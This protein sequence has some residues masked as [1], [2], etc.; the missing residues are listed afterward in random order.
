[1]THLENNKILYDLQHGF[2]SSR[3]C[4]TQLTTFIH[5]LT[6]NNNNNKQTDIIIMDFAKAFDKVPH[7]RLQYKL[8]YYGITGNTHTWITDFLS[9]RTQTVVLEGKQ[10]DK[11]HVTS[12][13]PQGTCLGPILFLIYINDF[14]EYIKHSTLRLFADDSIIYKTIHNKDDTDKLQQD[15][16]AA[17]QWETDWLM[18]FHPDKCNIISITSKRNKIHH[19]YKLHNHTLQQVESSKYLGITLQNNLKWDKHINNITANANRSL[20]FLK[21]NLKLNSPHI[22][23]HAYKALVR[24]KLEYCSSIWDPYNTNQIQQI[25]KPQRRA[26]RYVQNRYHNTSSVTDMLHTL[27]W[28]T[29]QIRRVRTRIILLYKIVHQQVAIDPTAILSPVDPRTRHAHQHAFKH[30]TATKDT[31]KYSFFPRTVTQWNLLPVAAVQCTTIEDFK[32]HIPYVA[33]ET[34]PH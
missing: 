12:G 26:A 4:E 24:P 13:V 16:N 1:M 5:D 15:L 32:A 31:Y 7:K 9:L 22:K 30:I 6:L 17:G 10:S 29:L 11:I 19:D 14:P 33:L 18:K 27:Q 25:E 20:G 21:R 23:E 28:P 8:K 2:R 34:L 3:S